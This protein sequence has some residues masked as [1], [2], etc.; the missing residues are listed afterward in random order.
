MHDTS[1]EDVL[2]LLVGYWRGHA[3]DDLEQ[4][5]LCREVGE[6]VLQLLDT[7]VAEEARLQPERY[8]AAIRSAILQMKQR[9]ADRSLLTQ[10]AR[11]ISLPSTSVSVSG[12]NNVTLAGSFEIGHSLNIGAA[13][14]AGALSRTIERT[15]E[16]LLGGSGA[17]DVCLREMEL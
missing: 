1:V 16:H 13:D 7:P 2:A 6:R 17:L 5:N 4:R 3:P 14:R 15:E 9:A 10:L 12:D 11:R 8:A